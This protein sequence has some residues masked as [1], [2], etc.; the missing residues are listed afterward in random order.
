MWERSVFALR[1]RS[2]ELMLVRLVTLVTI[3]LGATFATG[4]IAQTPPWKTQYFDGEANCDALARVRD[5][6]NAAQWKTLLTAQPVERPARLWIRVS[7]DT[8]IVLE[9][10]WVAA[11]DRQRVRLVFFGL[12]PSIEMQR[13][14]TN[15]PMR[16]YE[17]SSQALA[18]ALPHTLEPQQPW[19]FCLTNAP[20]L[21]SAA[22]SLEPAATFREADLFSAQRI[23]A[24][25]AVTLTMMLSAVF[26]GTRLRDDV[27]LWYVG[28]VAGF[29][30]FQATNTGLMARWLDFLPDGWRWV[31]L[32]QV[33]GIGL[34]VFC[35]TH[36]ISTFLSVAQVLPRT[37]RWLRRLAWTTWASTLTLVTV[38]LAL[39]NW[40]GVGAVNAIGNIV[41]NALTAIACVLALGTCAYLA[42]KRRRFALYL[43]V[44]WMPLLAVSILSAVEL[45]SG[46]PTPIWQP[47]LLPAAAFE[48]LILSAGMA[49][50]TL[51]LRNE[52]DAARMTAEI[53]PLTG[54]LN[55]R[56]LFNR[57][58]Q[59]PPDPTGGGTV[60]AL[61]Y[62]DLDFFKRI[63]DTHGHDAGDACLQ[64]FVKCAQSVLRSEDSVG[65]IGGEE[66]VM[67]L[68]AHDTAQAVAIAER[69]RSLLH[70]S[71]V[72]WRD[73][74]VAL[75]VSI[76]IARIDSQTNF[77]AAL[78]KADAALY[79]AKE[80]G[81]D[82]VCSDDAM[83]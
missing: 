77:D 83:A 19:Y 49:A 7:S 25:I 28:H 79:R 42:I 57:L 30:A 50:R 1:W 40:S 5:A 55:R 71:P 17:F 12:T 20:T 70:A 66:F 14:F 76:G 47:W 11:I 22:F 2:T 52:R 67:L 6:G 29:L 27:Y 60:H 45:I 44:G 18:I 13:R 63:N 31:W 32:A 64:H 51:D 4:A 43:L 9:L 58:A 74:V 62:C 72:V 16:P 73:R 37:D 23:A 24:C 65:R 54:A 26:F 8:R 36:F 78:T 61:L 48:A 15:Q 69:L 46:V 33:L 75:T 82:R 39:V 21:T 56:G 59:L 3:A 53:D 80:G 68:K 35:A 34:S 41:Q 38:Q 81:R 10:G